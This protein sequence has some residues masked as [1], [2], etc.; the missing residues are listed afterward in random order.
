MARTP[1]PLRVGVVGGG[2]TG[3]LTA[4]HLAD[5]GADVTV[6][7]AGDR[8]GGQVRSIEVAGTTVDV[9]AESLHTGAPGVLELLGRLGLEQ[10]VV[11]A[12]PGPTWLATRRGLRRLPAG[13]GPAGPTRLWPVATSRV[14]SP[15]GLLRAAGEPFVRGDDLDHDVAVG[16]Y[17]TR[18]F[19]PQLTDR[20]VDPLLGN[21]H[22]GDVHRLSL[23]AA[24]P[25]LD[26]AARRHRSLVLGRRRAPAGAPPRFVTLPGGLGRITDGLAADPRVEVR[27]SSRVDALLPLGDGHRIVTGDG[28][29][30][31]VDAVV[32]AIPAAPASRLV[33]AFARPAA[34]LLAL[35]ESAT[36]ATAILAYRAGDI[37][38]RRAARGNGV[39]VPSG[40]RRHL[41]AATFLTTKWP[42]LAASGTTLVRVSAGRAGDDRLG[43][44]D[45]EDLVRALRADLDELTG[46]SAVPL[47]AVVHRWPATMP[48]LVV[49]HRED[50]ATIRGHLDPHRITI[51][52][53]AYDGVGIASCLTAAAAAAQRVLPAPATEQ[54]A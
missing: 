49:G 13:M 41:K 15:G 42:H 17:L 20:L 12:N 3:L 22:A 6:L 47:A 7:E 43:G 24:T 29:C 52:G 44:L 50:I 40:T 48:Q 53:A 51:A 8:V 26:R 14:L 32:L 10:D 19:G 39:L 28:T 54:V 4:A 33:A 16:A 37:S 27:C 35:R 9:G 1:S 25:Q 23:A 45:D 2:I 18:R 31:D 5:G 46:T 21:L 11:E 38:D 36:V 34:R 30:L